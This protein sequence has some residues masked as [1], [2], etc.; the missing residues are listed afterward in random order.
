MKLLKIGAEEFAAALPSPVPPYGAA[1]RVQG[2]DVQTAGALTRIVSGGRY[3][4][5]PAG[6]ELVRIER[7]AGHFKWA[8]GETPFAAGDCFLAE[9]LE[10]YELNGA[11]EFTALRLRPDGEH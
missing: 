10:E 6:K 2:A 8:R 7:G 1:R 4:R 5:F 11:G 3:K 9:G